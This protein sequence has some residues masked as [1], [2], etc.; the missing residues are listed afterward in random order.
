[1]HRRIC[2][3]FGQDIPETETP[4]NHQGG[5]AQGLFDSAELERAIKEI[6][7]KQGPAEDALL[8]DAPDAKC[9]VYANYSLIIRSQS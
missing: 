2:L 5:Q 4:C 8:M 3:A 7:V 6:M 1:V 9:K